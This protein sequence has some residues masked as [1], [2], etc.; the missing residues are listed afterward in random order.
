M[1]KTKS[2]MTFNEYKKLAEQEHFG[3]D[4]GLFVVIDINDNKMKNKRTRNLNHNLETINDDSDC[5]YDVNM[6]I[7]SN[8]KNI[9]QRERENGCIVNCIKLGITMVF[10][11][12]LTYIIFYKF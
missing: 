9:K 3:N 8:I 10:T 2:E 4:W 5:D 11:T 7:E 6:D 1:N 12:L